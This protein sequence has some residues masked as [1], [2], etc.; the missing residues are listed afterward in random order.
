MAQEEQPTRFSLRTAWYGLIILLA[1]VPLSVALPWA[2]AEA[3]S[4]LLETALLHEAQRNLRIAGHVE[5][6]ADRLFTMMANKADPV[7]H[8]LTTGR[9]DGLLALLF[10]SVL[11]RE[12]ALHSLSLID[13]EGNVLAAEVRRGAEVG[14]FS[15]ASPEAVVPLHGR[16][17]VGS[18]FERDGRSM[19]TIAVPVLDDGAPI[20]VL[21]GELSAQDLWDSLQSQ[22]SRPS[23]VTYLVDS[24]GSLMTS[25]RR[26][27]PPR[28]RLL[29]HLGIV[30]S[31]LAREEWN[32][33][34]EYTG[35]SGAPVYGV[36]EQVGLLNWGVVS[37]IPAANIN[38]PI[39]SRMGRFAALGVLFIAVLAA[40]AISSVRKITETIT[41][42]AGPFGRA[43]Q[44]D[45][46]GRAKRSSVREL[47]TLASGFNSMLLEINARESSLGDQRLAL[48]KSRDRLRQHAE[49]QTAVAGLGQLALSCDLDELIDEA[50]G[51]VAS[52]L[53]VQLSLVLELL[54]DGQSLVLRA[55][56]GFHE[57]L[58]G[59]VVVP[60]QAASVAG[61]T[62]GST[63]PVLIEDL[64]TD[65]FSRSELLL[66]HGVVSGIS[67]LIHGEKE[68]FGIL[69]AYVS[70]ARKFTDDD[71]NFLLAIARILGATTNRVQAE[72]ERRRYEAML[73]QQQ[74]LESIGTLAGGVAHEINNP[75]SGIIG[76]ATLIEERLGADDP[77]REFAQEIGHEGARVTEIVRNLLSF[78][79]RESSSHSPALI[80]DIIGNTLSLVRT[81]IRRD[82]ID[83]QISVDANIPALR[84]HSQQIQQV[85]M[86]LFTN[87]RDA[88]NAR[89]EG[90]DDDKIMSLSAEPFH[91]DG[92]PWVRITVEDHG[93]GIPDD[94]ADRIFDPFFTTKDRAM[95]TGLGLSICRGI[96]EEHFGRLYFESKPGVCTRFHLELPISGNSTNE[97]HALQK[98]SL[99]TEPSP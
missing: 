48:E 61:L 58:V 83:L 38:G 68:P 7:S 30:R 46:S 32:T 24:R 97:Q 81:V 19:F 13:P 66:A 33:E 77:L 16:P 69:G 84:C 34:N 49:R 4:L 44:G 9:D 22:L 85:I 35:L 71:A 5:Q 89:Y 59:E 94:I 12:P 70:R 29:T 36:S 60:V 75:I 14:G 27:R 73:R 99:F 52:A 95:G 28:G 78:A 56:D 45:Y 6:E 10:E 79:R 21:I 92:E 86:N 3:H 25:A 82:Q 80:S 64:R 42:L 41:A 1:V 47:D 65:L 20:A 54:P 63:E 37:E 90:H 62:L 8:V 53:D 11:D 40:L 50:L 43:E 96:I 74:K 87:G 67:V 93:S 17:Y 31:H 23:V 57:G 76:Y 39:A 18:S 88:L 91:L 51:L 72:R 15:A 26:A 98:T 55:G 2:G